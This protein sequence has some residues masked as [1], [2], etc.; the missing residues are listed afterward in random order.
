[1]VS[2]GD[3]FLEEKV[4][5]IRDRDKRIAVYNNWTVGDYKMIINYF[6]QVPQV[7]MN[8]VK[9]RENNGQKG[10]C[11]SY[12]TKTAEGKE[13]QVITFCIKNHR[14]S[15]SQEEGETAI[16]SLEDGLIKDEKRVPFAP[17]NILTEGV[18]RDWYIVPW[19]KE[20]TKEINE[21]NDE[22][23]YEKL[24]LPKGLKIK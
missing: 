24:I 6:D 14:Y 9:A 11:Y 16:F 12:T 7:I 2:M 15:I 18:A 5:A 4:E 3:K 10:T 23:S 22:N 8:I 21:S 20:F 19:I 13:Y 17:V 1:M